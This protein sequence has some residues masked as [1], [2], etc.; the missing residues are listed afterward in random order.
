MPRSLRP[1]LPGIP[2]HVVQRGVNRAPCFVVDGDRERY[3]HWLGQA[4]LAAEVAVHAY[5]LMDNHVHLLMTAGSRGALSRTMHRLGT[6]YVPYFNKRHGRVGVLWEKRFH[7][8]LVDTDAYLVACYRYVE[9]NPVRAAMV[10]APGDYRWSSYRHNALGARDDLVTPHPVL[11]AM[12]LDDA[13]RRAAYRAI[14][15]AGR[16]GDEWAEI[17]REAARNGA[18]GSAGFRQRVAAEA[19]RDLDRG[20]GRPVKK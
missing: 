15:D 12:G 13:S 16:P 7:G 19:S 8:C 1:D 14:V 18:F 3:L 4:A 5:V 9:L 2:V 17:R 11:R 10:H 20:R 6:H